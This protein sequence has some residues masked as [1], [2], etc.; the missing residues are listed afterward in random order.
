MGEDESSE[1]I[2]FDNNV[3]TETVRGECVAPPGSMGVAIRET[4][5]FPVVFDMKPGG[6]MDGKLKQ[7]DKV[8][9]V[10]D[11]DTKGMS[12]DDFTKLLDTKNNC[13]KKIHYLRRVSVVQKPDQVQPVFTMA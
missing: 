9:K 13:E 5:D 10:D 12:G 8:V 7:F 1:Y 4:D 11:V 3:N 2:S 6:P